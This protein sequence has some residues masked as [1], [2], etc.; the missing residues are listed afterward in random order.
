MKE[1]ITLTL[2]Q[3]QYQLRFIH[4]QTT[5]DV[6]HKYIGKLF[7][8]M[9]DFNDEFIETL[10][11][12]MGRPKFQN[13]FTIPFKDLSTL[14]INQFVNM[15]SEYITQLPTKLDPV[16]DA[17]LITL[18]QAFLVEVNHTKYFLTLQY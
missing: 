8:K 15:M 3:L 17:D 4:W 14:D 13:D 6:T 12:K 7:D 9:N 2:L 11:G 10:Y 16:K 5:G 1:T 18:L